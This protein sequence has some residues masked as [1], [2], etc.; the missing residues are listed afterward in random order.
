[1]CRPVHHL[2]R[3]RVIAPADDPTRPS[4]YPRI[5]PAVIM[6]VTSGDHIL[7]GHQ[8]RW[9]EGRYSLLAGANICIGARWRLCVLFGIV[10]SMFL[11]M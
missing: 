9:V 10:C 5:D 2:H 7:L 1:M 11:L 8:G 3:R 4:L 6:A